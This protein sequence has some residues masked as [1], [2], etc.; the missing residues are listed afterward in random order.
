MRALPR[1]I[2]TSSRPNEERLSAAHLR[3]LRAPVRMEAA[4]GPRLGTGAVLLGALQAHLSLSLQINDP[5]L[6]SGLPAGSAP[7]QPEC[8][9]R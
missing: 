7:Y 5:S 6:N 9:C 4:L 2:K 3:A 8:R 1:A